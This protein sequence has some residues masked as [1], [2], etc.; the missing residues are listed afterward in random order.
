M[1]ALE[2]SVYI[3]IYVILF[4][5]KNCYKIMS[6]LCVFIHHKY[7]YNLAYIY[8]LAVIEVLQISRRISAKYI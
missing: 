4:Y 7:N 1:T 3:I 8:Y 5:F 2:N 6:I